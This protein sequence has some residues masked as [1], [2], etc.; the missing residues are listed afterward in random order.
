MPREEWNKD[1]QIA[2]PFL[3]FL[4]ARPLIRPNRNFAMQLVLARR[5]MVDA[6]QV[7]QSRTS[8]FFLKAVNNSVSSAQ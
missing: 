7:M 1:K 5:Q 3:P 2:L 4:F 8:S 6:E